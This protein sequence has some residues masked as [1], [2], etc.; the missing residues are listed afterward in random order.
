MTG[1]PALAAQ[2][3]SQVERC[4]QLGISFPDALTAVREAYATVITDLMVDEQN[5]PNSI[6][7]RYGIISDWETG[8]VPYNCDRAYTP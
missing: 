7:L 1:R 6:L 8:L 2:V 5:V 3:R 4:R